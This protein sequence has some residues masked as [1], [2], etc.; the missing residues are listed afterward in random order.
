MNMRVGHP[1][2]SVLIVRSAVRDLGI[3]FVHLPARLACEWLE[4]HPG[5]NYPLVPPSVA[6]S[7]A[8]LYSSILRVLSCGPE[9]GGAECRHDENPAIRTRFSSHPRRG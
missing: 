5:G 6:P 1:T 7:H 4:A 9:S 8:Q 2:A 3:F